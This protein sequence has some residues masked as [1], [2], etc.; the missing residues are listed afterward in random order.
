MHPLLLLAASLAA[1]AGERPK[2]ADKKATRIHREA[3]QV[4][5][6]CVVARDGGD[7]VGCLREYL[8]A[9][10]SATVRAR[11]EDWPAHVPDVPAA[12]KRLDELLLDE[13]ERAL[14]AEATDSWQALAATLDNPGEA[15][16]EAIQAWLDEWSMKSVTAGQSRRPVEPAELL[17]ARDALHRVVREARRVVMPAGPWSGKGRTTSKPPAVAPRLVERS[18]KKNSVIDDARWFRDQDWTLPVVMRGPGATSTRIPTLR[19]EHAAGV[20]DRLDGEPLR[21][22]IVDGDLRL[23]IYGAGAVRTRL[24][25]HEAEG[26]SLI[27]S[28]DFSAWTRAPETRRGDERFVDQ[29]LTWAQAREGVVYVS[30]DHRTYARASMGHNAYLSAIDIETGSLLWRSEP[31]V[32]NSRNFVVHDDLIYCGYGF[33]SE[34][35]FL[36][37]I[38]RHS[39]ALLQKTKLKTGPDYLLLRD[40]TLYVRTYDMDY[41]FELQ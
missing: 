10:E 12:R 33:T 35:D 27:R 38:D 17:E 34:P 28:F 32:C 13:A 26:G 2:S 3:R 22:V 11:G 7:E 8:G 41:V 19:G 20:D 21:M 25:I 15:E 24:G 29:S 31:L 5:I 36:T 9:Y 1:T 16:I 37:V 39:G 18:A 40:D 14:R 23:G 4:W 30:H 6:R